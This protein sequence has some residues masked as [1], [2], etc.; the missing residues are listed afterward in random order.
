[1]KKNLTDWESNGG[2]SDQQPSTYPLSYRALDIHKVKIDFYISP[3]TLDQ[4]W[5]VDT[6]LIS[7]K[8]SGGKNVTCMIENVTKAESRIGFVMWE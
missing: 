7:L 3:Q 4:Y 1:M 5:S 2:P 8:N 6:C